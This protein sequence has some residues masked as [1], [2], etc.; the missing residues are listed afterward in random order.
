MIALSVKQQTAPGAKI[1]RTPRAIIDRPL[2]D[3]QRA[4]NAAEALAAAGVDPRPTA[5]AEVIRVTPLM[6]SI[7]IRRL[8]QAELWRWSGEPKGPEVEEVAESPRLSYARSSFDPP[9]DTARKIAAE[10]IANDRPEA[11]KAG[12]TLAD[13]VGTYLAEWRSGKVA[14]LGNGDDDA[15]EVAA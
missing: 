3:M 1:G 14:D 10:M 12:P 8:I 6:A 7:L 5:L 4:Y 11:A 13:I 2:S 15:Q 9:E